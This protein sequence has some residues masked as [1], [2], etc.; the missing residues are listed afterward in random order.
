MYEQLYDLFFTYTSLFHRSLHATRSPFT[1]GYAFHLFPAEFCLVF[2]KRQDCFSGKLRLQLDDS[3]VLVHKK[4]NRSCFYLKKEKKKKSLERSLVIASH[5][6]S[7]LGSGQQLSQGW[8]FLE[9]KCLLC[10]LSEGVKSTGC[11]ALR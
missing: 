4:H 2:G 1:V 10:C 5:F 3:F 9:I 7:R 11:H 6:G 8:V